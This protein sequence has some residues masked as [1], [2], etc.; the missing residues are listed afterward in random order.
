MT[1]TEMRRFSKTVD[2]VEKDDDERTATGAVLVPDEVDHQLDF[3]RADAIERLHTDDPDAGVMHSVFHGES[4]LER[5]EV[6]EESETIGGE[7]FQAGTWVMTR[8]YDNDQLWQ[9]VKDGVL[10]GF[11]IGGEVTEQREYTADEVPDDVSFPDGVPD[12]QGAVE[13]V[14]GNID[15]VSDVDV[16]AVPRAEHAVVKSAGTL[17]K[18]LL[19]EVGG[20]NEFVEV[21]LDRGHDEADARRLWEL[22]QTLKATDEETD[23]RMSDTDTDSDESPDKQLDEIDDATLGK[24]LK[25]LFLGAPDDTEADDGTPPEDSDDVG[26]AEKAGRVLSE[27]NVAEAK[28]IH[29]HAERMLRSEGVGSHSQTVRTYNADDHDAFTLE[30]VSKADAEESDDDETEKAD[31]QADDHPADADHDK[32]TDETEEP[33]AWAESL[34]DKVEEIESR[35]DEV[36]ED[37]EKAEDLDDAPEWAQDLGKQ[38]DELGER[39]DKLS[40]NSADTDQVGGSEETTDEQPTDAEAFKQRLVGVGGD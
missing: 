38:V 27:A 11:S 3:L 39:V 23:E 34:I 19:D 10:G 20:E 35:V 25:R 17:G 32:M 9:L 26:A 8:R 1:D 33:P 40:K 4:T 13:I 31:A 6:L 16:P 21:M 29:D 12:D 7:E 14:D 24:R 37:S 2:I 30:S 22:L 18:N 28:A 36:D 15:E 5:N